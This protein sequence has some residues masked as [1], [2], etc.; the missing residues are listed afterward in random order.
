MT[1]PSGRKEGSFYKFWVAVKTWVELNKYNPDEINK[2]LTHEEILFIY[3]RSNQL[4]NGQ[5]VSDFEH[6]SHEF[7]LARRV[8]IIVVPVVWM[9]TFPQYFQVKHKLI[10]SMCFQ[11]LLLESWVKKIKKESTWCQETM[12]S[13][14]SFFQIVKCVNLQSFLESP[15]PILCLY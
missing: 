10:T 3:K 12:A 8:S 6:P 13:K 11:G 2:L 1:F 9:L 7:Q 15:P 4:K 14:W 5:I